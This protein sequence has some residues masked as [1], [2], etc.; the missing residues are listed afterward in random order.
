MGRTRDD[1]ATFIGD[2]F[3]ARDEN[4]EF[5]ARVATIFPKA[6]TIVTI[7]GIHATQRCAFI[8]S[9]N[10]VRVQEGKPPLTEDEE[11]AEMEQSVDLF[12]RE[13]G[14][15][16]RPDPTRMELAFE[17]DE[18][19]QEEVPTKR[20]IKYLMLDDRRVR[21]SLKRRGDCW[22][23]FQPPTEPKK[24]RQMIAEARS[25]IAGKAIYYYSPVTGTRWLTYQSFRA[26]ANLDDT[27]LREHLA[28]ISTYMTRTNHNGYPEIDLFMANHNLSLP[29]LESI[30]DCPADELR[31]RF[32]A[33]CLRVCQAVPVQY[34]PD[35]LD[36]PIWRNRMF[37]LLMTQRDDAL[38]DDQTMG[39][40]PD[41]SMRVEWLPGARID[42]GE[43]ILDPAMD[44]PQRD[45]Q[46]KYVSPVMRGL[47]FNLVQD[48][49]DLEYINLGSVLPSADRN[50]ERGGRREVY[51]AQIKQR[52]ATSEVLQILRMQ[53]WGVR[54]RLDQGKSLE[55]AMTEAEEYTQYVLDRRLACRQ[56]QMNVPHR[57]T[58]RKV[59]EKYDGCNGRY[60]GQNIWTPYF[61]RDYIAG[62]ATNQISNR[63]LADGAY[64]M[65]FARLLGEAAASNIILGR[66]ELIDK[67]VGEV[68]FDVGDEIVVEDAEGMPVEIVVSDQVGTF[69]DWTGNLERRAP[70][71]AA[72]VARRL[73]AVTLRKEFMEAFLAGFV[74]RFIR[75]QEEYNRNRRA[76]DTLFNH[77]PWDDGGSLSCRWAHTMKR[78]T[79]SNAKA[80]ADLIRAAIP[81]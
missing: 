80:L 36:E 44:E 66:A 67:T 5:K 79:N 49:G 46:E 75:T 63:K 64:A 62:V 6:K 24:I 12:V 40:D 76:F 56:L 9:L 60:A 35:D 19:L 7:P 52:R 20:R 54:E 23:I 27:E 34:Q 78:L 57:Q 69:V 48:Y 58:T 4:G 65:T 68:V 47:I 70:E 31:T 29:D 50:P 1:M 59:S 45:H 55:Q 51:V 16:I 38:V 30:A 37:G 26:L 77:R 32:D 8:D 25:G 21:D 81:V 42:A 28:E 14:V 41:F 33:L 10:Q 61:Q 18:V 22:R 74:Q 53:K 43:L 39:L 2:N 15:F 17:A 71:Y 72:C 13:Q 11:D 73:T 3:S